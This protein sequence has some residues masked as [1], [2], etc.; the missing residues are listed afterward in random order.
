M[1]ENNIIQKKELVCPNCGE[2]IKPGEKC[3]MSTNLLKTKGKRNPHY[4]YSWEG[5]VRHED[6]FIKEQL[7]LMTKFIMS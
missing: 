6:C 1:K 2:R 7:K 3:V 4:K 5:L